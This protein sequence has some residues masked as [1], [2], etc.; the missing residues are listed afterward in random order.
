MSIKFKEMTPYHKHYCS[1][2]WD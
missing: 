1:K 2:V